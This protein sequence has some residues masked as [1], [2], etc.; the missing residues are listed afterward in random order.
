MK[1]RFQVLDIF[2][3]IFASIVALFHLSGFSNTPILNNP[4]LENSDM[5]VDFFFVLSGFVIVYNYESIANVDQ[6]KLF[7][8]KRLLRIYPLHLLMLL[9]FVLMEVSKHFASAYIQVNRLENEHNNIYSFFTSLFLLNSVKL[10]D[11]KDVSWNIPSWSISAEMICYVVFGL[12]LLGLSHYNMQRKK[13]TIFSLIVLIAISLLIIITHTFQVNFSY[14]YGFLR[15]IIGFFSGALCYFAFNTYYNSVKQVKDSLFDFFETGILAII[16][17]MMYYGAILKD[18]SLVYEIAFFI[19]IFIFS[20]EKGILSRLLKKSTFL[21]NVGTYSYSIYMTHALLLS[22]FN[23]VFIRVLK[24]E[25]SSYS[26][27]VFLNYYFIY[28]VSQWTYTHI[29]M[30]FKFKKKVMQ[31]V[32]YKGSA[33]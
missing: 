30:R 3:G 5:F 23:I 28:K 26:F 27:L 7:L 4:F 13:S 17:I 19:A 2:R 24:F 32:A 8:Q 33:V 21:K 16:C 14:D 20:F 11:V 31:K 22:L 29:E 1:H 12:T 10:F 25:P 15:G 18:I 6:F 9:L